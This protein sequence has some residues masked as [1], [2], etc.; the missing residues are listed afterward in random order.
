M[1][2]TM[3]ISDGIKKSAIKDYETKLFKMYERILKDKEKMFKDR[4]FQLV[5]FKQR[6][7]TKN[8]KWINDTDENFDKV[9]FDDGYKCIVTF[10]LYKNGRNYIVNNK[11]IM[12]NYYITDISR[13]KQ[14]DNKWVIKYFVLNT[15]TIKDIE[16]YYVLTST[17]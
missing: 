17:L 3:T 6:F 12:N 7:D 1:N 4:D 2:N 8:K 16:Y 5:L 10:A 13:R 15:D 9:E 11:K 14:L